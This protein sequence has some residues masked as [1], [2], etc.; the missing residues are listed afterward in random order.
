[1]K[2][3]QGLELLHKCHPTE[4]R[5]YPKRP[6]PRVASPKRKRGSR[7]FLMP[8][9]WVPT[10]RDY[11]QPSQPILTCYRCKARGCTHIPRVSEISKSSL[12]DQPWQSP[13]PGGKGHVASPHM[14]QHTPTALKGT[15]Q[16]RR[17]GGTGRNPDQMS[18]QL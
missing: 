17:G 5:G 7:T 6:P 4:H 2:G 14:G 13:R 3:S 16:G 1:M 11:Y 10:W 9:Y 8:S 18:R 15:G 12:P